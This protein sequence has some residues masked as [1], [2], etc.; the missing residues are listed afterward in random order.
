MFEKVWVFKFSSNF[1]AYWTTIS[2]IISPIPTR[3]L[4]HH[5]AQLA[6]PHS[7]C[8]FT[9]IYIYI[10]IYIMCIYVHIFL[11][12]FQTTNYILSHLIICQLIKM[13]IYLFIVL[14]FTWCNHLNTKVGKQIQKEKIFLRLLQGLNMSTQ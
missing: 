4:R 12:S 1:C 14:P 6:S 11:S 2:L 7:M 13:T 3:N 9:Y 5:F 8:A 10:Y